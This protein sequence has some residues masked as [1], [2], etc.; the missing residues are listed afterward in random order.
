MDASQC[1]VKHDRK[2][3]PADQITS[4][5]SCQ[6]FLLQTSLLHC[7]SPVHLDLKHCVTKTSI[8]WHL[9]YLCLKLATRK[10]L[11]FSMG[12]LPKCSRVLG[13]NALD[14]CLCLKW[15]AAGIW[16]LLRPTMACR[17]LLAST[18]TSLLSSG[19]YTISW[20]GLGATTPKLS[21]T[22]C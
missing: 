22:P 13:K 11:T 3:P 8:N 6:P 9:L 18:P 20:S 5:Q 14:F 15:K 17:S 19:S 4:A 2:I 10:L 7:Y 16:S 1:P 12:R 21:C